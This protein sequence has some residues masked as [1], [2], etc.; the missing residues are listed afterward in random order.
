MSNHVRTGHP[1]RASANT[2]GGHRGCCSLVVL[3]ANDENG[4]HADES[5]GAPRD[6]QQKSIRLPPVKIHLAPRL[7]L[8]EN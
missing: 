2:C 8:H 6:G 3:L 1:V 5:C 4:Q 7:D